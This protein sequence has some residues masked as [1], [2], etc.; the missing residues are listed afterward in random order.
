MRNNRLS[1]SA[2]HDLRSRLELEYRNPKSHS[3]KIHYRS[4]NSIELILPL[5]QGNRI[6]FCHVSSFRT[7]NECDIEWHWIINAYKT[8]MVLLNCHNFVINIIYLYNHQWWRDPNL[9]PLLDR[10][11]ERQTRCGIQ[12]NQIHNGYLQGARN[13]LSFDMNQYLK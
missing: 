13:L 8:A 2:G 1:H 10:V 12:Q 9:R 11:I 3:F 6:S 4:G 7:M 5:W